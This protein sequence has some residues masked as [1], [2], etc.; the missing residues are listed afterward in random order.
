VTP[1]AARA[2]LDTVAAIARRAGALA[3]RHY[4][5]VTPQR[6]ADQSFV[7]EA[8]R[9]V[10]AQVREEL[11]AAFPGDTILGEEMGRRGLASAERVWLI[12]PIDGTTNF[13]HQIPFWCVAIGL[14]ENGQASLGVLY[15]PL[16]DDL[17][18]GA[19]GLG[20]W[21]GAEPISVWTDRGPFTRT[22]PVALSAGLARRDLRF[23]AA[24]RTRCMG[25]A[26][27]HFGLVARG[28]CRAG[29]WRGDFAWDL[30]AGIA[31]VRAAGGVVRTFA[32]EEPDLALL[33]DGRPQPWGLAACGPGSLDAVLAATAPLAGGGP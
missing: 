15:Q 26:Q 29:L 1:E 23:P 28:S 6:K 17:L 24:V 9:A 18:A 21:C 11:A 20:A 2:R 16:S 27:L 3:L 8:D 5:A 32:G 12:D 25:S 4:R 19:V 33:L 7:T 22:D 31:L 14:L 13:V 30:V 10:E